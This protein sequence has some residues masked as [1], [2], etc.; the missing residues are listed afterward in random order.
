MNTLLSEKQKN[1]VVTALIDDIGEDDVI[2]IACVTVKYSKEGGYA[3]RL[4][5][6]DIMSVNEPPGVC[7]N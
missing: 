3:F 6:D 2:G 5:Y 1:S 4:I 7:C